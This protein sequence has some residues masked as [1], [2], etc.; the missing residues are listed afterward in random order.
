VCYWKTVQRPHIFSLRKRLIGIPGLFQGLFGQEGHNGVY[1]WVN[2][3]DLC[4]MGFHHFKGGQF[5]CPDK[6]G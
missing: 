3:L 5:F 1:L 6:T 2:A 4:Q